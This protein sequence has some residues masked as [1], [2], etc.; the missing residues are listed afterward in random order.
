MVALHISFFCVLVG[1]WWVK[2]SWWWVDDT[3]KITGMSLTMSGRE[4]AELTGKEHRNVMRDIRTMLEELHGEGG[5]LSFEQ[6]YTNEQRKKQPCFSLP[7]RETLILVSGYNI[8][9]R[10][11]IIDRWQELEAQVAAPA[12]QIPKSFAEGGLRPINIFPTRS[13]HC[14]P[15][16]MRDLMSVLTGFAGSG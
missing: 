7:K 8:Q 10:A 4:I 1:H 15:R 16:A 12:F 6:S 9:M 5:V 13:H 3:V 11:K 14:R 2:S